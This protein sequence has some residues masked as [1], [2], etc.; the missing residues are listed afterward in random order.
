MQVMDNYVD[1]GINVT[2]NEINVADDGINGVIGEI[3]GKKWLKQ[4]RRS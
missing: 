4:W 1:A 3:N 2:G